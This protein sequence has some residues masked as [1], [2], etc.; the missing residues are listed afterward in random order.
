MQNNKLRK[1]LYNVRVQLKHG[2]TRGNNPRELSQEEIDALTVKKN[3]IENEMKRN[4]SERNIQRINGHVSNESN[5]V[6]ASINKATEISNQ[7]LDKLLKYHEQSPPQI[8]EDDLEFMATIQKTLR[9]KQMN[10]LLLET[11]CA[12]PQTV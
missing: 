9:V 8:P 2:K 12:F 4:V 5:R 1:E 6:I 10:Q 3:Q 11:N 7:K